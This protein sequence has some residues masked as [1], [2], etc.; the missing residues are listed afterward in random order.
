MSFYNQ[1]DDPYVPW[2][3]PVICIIIGFFSLI[4]WSDNRPIEYSDY[5]PTINDENLDGEN[6][7][8]YRF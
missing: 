5:E 3:I 4:W 7:Y 6:G 1:Y 8:P 2:Y